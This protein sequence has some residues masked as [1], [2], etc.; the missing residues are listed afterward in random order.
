MVRGIKKTIKRIIVL[1]LVLVMAVTCMFM[2]GC[3]EEK[4]EPKDYGDSKQ[5]GLHAEDGYIYLNGELFY[6]MG[7]CWHGGF[8]MTRNNSMKKKVDSYFAKLAEG[9]V[10]FVRVMMGVFYPW[11]VA[12]EYLKNKDDYYEDMDYFISL[13]EKYHIGIIASLCWNYDTF[14]K[15]CGEE[16]TAITDPYSKCN[17]ILRQYVKEIVTRYN[18]SPAIWGWELGNE[19]NLGAELTYWPSKDLNIKYFE[20][21]EYTSMYYQI[22]SDEI[23]KYDPYRMITNGDGGY[24]GSWRSLR[25]TLGQSW[26]PPDTEEDYR[27]LYKFVGTGSVD[28]LSVHYP[29]LETLPRFVER[30]REMGYSYYVGEFENYDLC[31]TSGLDDP[32]QEQAESG[33]WDVANAILEADVQISSHWCWGRYIEQDVD[34]TSVEPGLVTKRDGTVVYQNYFVWENIKKINQ[35]YVEAGKNKADDYW[36]NVENLLYKGE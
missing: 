15:Y 6:G 32:K 36:A 23:R 8:S 2:T 19:G 18:D 35:D 4:K 26:S 12:N 9:H 17:A 33:W 1:A 29:V 30:A 5:Y 24:R 31:F 13:A 22:F 20:T 25:N 27:E 3:R 28:T 16:I 21:S 34:Y 7:F 14:M 11:Q 10:P